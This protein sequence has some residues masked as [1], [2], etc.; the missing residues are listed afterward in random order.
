MAVE[1]GD[2][3]SR[4]ESNLDP[5]RRVPTSTHQHGLKGMRD[6]WGDIQWME[7]VSPFWGKFFPSPGEILSIVTPI[8]IAVDVNVLYDLSVV[9]GRSS[10]RI[11]E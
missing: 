10:V 3:L 11:I 5:S 2:P 1:K 6:E 7:T 4:E 8:L 9:V